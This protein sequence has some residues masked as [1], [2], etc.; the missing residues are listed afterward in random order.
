MTCDG[1]RFAPAQATCPRCARD[2]F[3]DFI[4]DERLQSS[5][6]HSTAGS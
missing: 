4:A 5:I 2:R 6:I 1:T 3:G